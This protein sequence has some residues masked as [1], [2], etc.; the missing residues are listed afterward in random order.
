MSTPLHLARRD[1]WEVDQYP[2]MGFEAP[3][4]LGSAVKSKDAGTIS[5]EQSMEGQSG[6][7][8]VGS[9]GVRFDLSGE[10][11]KLRERT[12]SVGLFAFVVFAVLLALGI[13]LGRLGNFVLPV[14]LFGAIGSIP[15]WTWIPVALRRPL[16]DLTIGPLGLV[17][18]NTRGSELRYSWTDPRF[19]MLLSHPL[20]DEAAPFRTPT[21]DWRIQLAPQTSSGLVPDACYEYLVNTARSA[22]LSVE[23]RKY[24]HAEARR[25]GFWMVETAARSTAAPH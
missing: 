17:G 25:G 23:D 20:A 11:S 19:R 9:S 2:P 10:D 4:I 22:G 16:A 8:L 18:H 3:L 6:A 15:I 24:Y 7:P 5:E 14:I 21:T 13:E 1:G 12:R